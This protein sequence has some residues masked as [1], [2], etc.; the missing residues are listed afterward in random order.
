[1]PSRFFGRNLGVKR[2]TMGGLSGLALA[3]LVSTCTAATGGAL[4]L[5]RDGSTRLLGRLH[6][7]W[8]TMQ[9]LQCASPA[10]SPLQC[11][12]AVRGAQSW[13]LSGW[14]VALAWLCGVLGLL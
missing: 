11:N 9:L 10:A 1:M 3:A 4:G 8:H 7:L 5:V 6:A 13:L 14:L 12:A 2:H